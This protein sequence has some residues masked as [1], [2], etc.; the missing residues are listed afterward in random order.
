MVWLTFCRKHFQTHFQTLGTFIQLLFCLILGTQLIELSVGLGN[1][2][3]SNRQQAFDQTNNDSVYRLT[4]WGRVMHIYVG[5]LTII[6]S[7]N[8]LSPGRRQA[9]IWTNAGIL[10]IGLLGTN[11]NEIWIEIYSRKCIWKCRLENGGHLSRPQ[12]VNHIVLMFCS[13]GVQ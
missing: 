2:L 3:A 10:L 6:G 4:H 7:N 9:I 12:G 11:F 5:K 13:T 8:G 1:G